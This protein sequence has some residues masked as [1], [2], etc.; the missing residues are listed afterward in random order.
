MH[1]RKLEKKNVYFSIVS[2][3]FQPQKIVSPSTVLEMQT[4][5]CFELSTLLVSFLIGCGHNA[6]VIQGY[7]AENVCNNDLRNIK[8]DLPKTNVCT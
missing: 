6:F 1:S 3:I 8:L 2:T 5:N 4:A 7:A